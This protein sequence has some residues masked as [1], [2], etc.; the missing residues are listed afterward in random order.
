[1]AEPEAR[2]IGRAIGRK[3]ANVATDRYLTAAQTLSE[4]LRDNAAAEDMRNAINDGAFGVPC[5]F[6][7][8]NQCSIYANR[9]MACRYQF[10]VD[11]DDLLCRLV[12]GQPIRVPYLNLQ[13]EQAAYASAMGYNARMADIRDW[14]PAA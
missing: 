9:P 5:T 13:G 10:S 3:P 11:D 14:F 2:E 8:D 12:P 6:L 4:D 1:M 7:V